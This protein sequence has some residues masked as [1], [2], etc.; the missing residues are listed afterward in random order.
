MHAIS[1]YHGISPTNKQTQPHTHRQDRLQYTA[2]QLARSIIRIIL[3]A[4]DENSFP[5]VSVGDKFQWE[6]YL[7]VFYLAAVPSASR[8]YRRDVINADS[9][10]AVYGHITDDV[11][12]RS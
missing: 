8:R 12:V 9:A 10:S 2:P 11:D 5:K 6:T 7:S 4:Y 3:G 1:S